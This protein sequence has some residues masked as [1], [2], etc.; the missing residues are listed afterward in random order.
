MRN[1]ELK[2][3]LKMGK[4]NLLS[5]DRCW[6]C[7]MFIGHWFRMETLNKKLFRKIICPPLK[8][9]EKT[10]T[11]FKTPNLFPQIQ[12]PKFKFKNSQK[13]WQRQPT[14]LYQ[15]GSQKENDYTII[16]QYSN[17]QNT[18]NILFYFVFKCKLQKWTTHLLSECSC[19]MS[20]FSRTKIN[21]NLKYK[22]FR[23]KG[24]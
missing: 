7:S 17:A 24:M 6:D 10:T 16:V 9:K 5:T 13:M 15:L 11:R 4:K 20:K 21:Q 19:F 22:N 2:G 23:F 12:N 18:W 14:Q 3:K 1:I 8:E